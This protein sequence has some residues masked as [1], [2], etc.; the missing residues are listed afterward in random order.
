MIISYEI[1][2]LKILAIL[3]LESVHHL[4][5]PNTVCFFYHCPEHCSCHRTY[6]Q[7]QAFYA[8]NCSVWCD[9]TM[10]L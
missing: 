7:M 9:K 8:K 2:T 4:I 10:S 5:T 3:D 1:T 6:H